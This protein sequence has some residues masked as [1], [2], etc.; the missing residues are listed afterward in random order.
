M[1]KIVRMVM[2][3]GKIYLHR[4]DVV[5]LIRQAVQKAETLD[6]RESLKAL[7]DSFVDGMFE[8]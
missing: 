7:A 1:E 6:G 3:R 5:D 2:F 8:S 4:D